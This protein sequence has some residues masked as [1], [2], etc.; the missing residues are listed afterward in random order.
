MPHAADHDLYAKL[1]QLGHPGLVVF[2]S[3]S[4]GKSKAIVHDLV[5]ILEKFKVP[6]HRMTAITFLLYDHLGGVN[7]MLYQLSNGGCIVTVQD[8]SPDTV[9]KAVERY[10]V[11][12]LPT[13]P[14]FISLMLLS[15][16]YKRYDLSSLKT[17]SYGTEPMPEVTLKRFH[18]LFPE[19]R[20]QQTYGLSELGVLRSK[21]KSSDS[22][23]VKIGGEGFETRVA[24]GILQIKARSAMLGYLN[25]PNPFTEDGWIDTGDLVEEDG[26]YL[27]I[28]GRKSDII[29]VGGEKV[30][31]AEVEGV[32]EEMENVAE[33]TVHGRKNAIVGNVVCAR[34]TL[35]RHEDEK[36][37]SRRV[38]K[39]CRERLARYKVPVQ[40][41]IVREEQHS[42]RFK[43]IRN[44]P[45]EPHL[46]H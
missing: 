19:I 7:T 20:M 1:R 26:D 2:S 16:A 36:A 27:R 30:Y 22:L 29:N 11:N 32:I 9:L 45:S 24:D 6:R 8:R 41:D 31:P 13:S 46:A 38:K 43:K 3:G 12:L 33:A 40:V 25:A 44:S 42:D 34:V 39:H 21:S 18:Q 28:L 5:P 17:V 35:L 37:F 15:E 4:T 23:L 10:N 14:T